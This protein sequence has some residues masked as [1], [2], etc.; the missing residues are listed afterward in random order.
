MIE[1]EPTIAVGICENREN[2]QIKLNGPFMLGD[3]QIVGPINLRASS[4]NIKGSNE[5][6]QGLSRREFLATPAAGSTFSVN[7]VAIGVNFHWER[8]QEQTFRGNLRLQ[9]TSDGKLTVINELGLEDYLESVIASEMSPQA[10]LEFLKAHAVMSRS[11]LAAML[12]RQE[13]QPGALRSAH[14]P[15]GEIRR[16]Y[17]REDHDNFDVCAD[18]H[19]QR[20]QGLPALPGGQAAEAVTATR[21]LFLTH[22]GEICDARFHKACGG[23]TEDFATAWEDK[24]VP[25]LTSVSDTV[26]PHP[27]LQT[28]AEAEKWLLDAP[29]AYCNTNDVTILKQILP[30][31]D[32]ETVDFYRW[33]TAYTPAALEKIIGE[34]TGRELGAIC[35]LM[36]LARGPS[37]RIHR[38]RIRGAKASL[39]VGKELE[40]RRVLSESHLLSSAFTVFT[41]R[42]PSGVPVRFILRGAGWGH[43]VGLC[44]IG[45]AVMAIRGRSAPEILQHY[46]QG[47]TLQKLY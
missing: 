18:D 9:A 20:Y 19:C 12:A 24:T 27:P 10:P 29:D 36:P 22:A 37:G 4:G 47:A 41:E 46:F 6:G 1:V 42:D 45:A 8:R 26:L 43:G 25:Y 30:S 32:R 38:L 7:D 28:E 34:K 23:R 35:E 21:G 39:V 5:E 31:F 17:G 2:L 16:W 11:W 13:K 14:L 44:Q 40:I 33:Q 15:G 3:R